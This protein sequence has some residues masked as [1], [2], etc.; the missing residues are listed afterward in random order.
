M[1]ITFKLIVHTGLTRKLTECGAVITD[2][3]EELFHLCKTLEKCFQKGVA[4]R[5]NAIGFPKLPEAWY[6]M[7]EIAGKND[8]LTKLYYAQYPSLL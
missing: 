7:A 3:T 5:M 6:W 8:R 1:F 4:I 2:E